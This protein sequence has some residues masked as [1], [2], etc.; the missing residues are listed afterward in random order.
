MVSLSISLT[1][2]FF[3]GFFFLCGL[4]S[5]CLLSVSKSDAGHPESSHKS[6]HPRARTTSSWASQ[7]MVSCATNSTSSKLSRSVI[8]GAI[9]TR[10]H[11]VTLRYSPREGVKCS[12]TSQL[13]QL[14]HVCADI[15]IIGIGLH[16][17]AC[18]ARHS[19]LI[20]PPLL[21]CASKLNMELSKHLQI[22]QKSNT[23]VTPRKEGPRYFQSSC[24]R[25]SQSTLCLK[26]GQ[27]VFESGPVASSACK[28]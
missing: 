17:G 3:F 10:G 20:D 25:Q 4:P 9:A 8:L 13:S 19:Q 14:T 16:L 7:T 18:A 22:L 6:C 28:D 1:C 11:L 23:G 15:L 2:R 5:P 27:E 21:F 12:T 24:S 26:R